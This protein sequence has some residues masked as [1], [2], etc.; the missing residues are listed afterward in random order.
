MTELET[1]ES[2]LTH[3]TKDR[4]MGPQRRRPQRKPQRRPMM[5][6]ADA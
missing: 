6:N 3:M 5:S 4:P 1:A 2:N